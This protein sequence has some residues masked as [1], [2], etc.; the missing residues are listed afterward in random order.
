MALTTEEKEK[1]INDFQIHKADTGS[2]NVQIA[3]LTQEIN[4]LLK[5]LK[6]NPK[7]NHSKRGLLKMV[8]KRKRLLKYLERKDKK[9]FNA[10]VKKLGL[11]TK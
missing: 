11:K 4:R 7:D 3:V 9:R 1:I 8:I 5:H 2:A 10:V 6:T